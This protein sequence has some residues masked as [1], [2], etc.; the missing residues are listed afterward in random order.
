[1]TIVA[2]LLPPVCPTKKVAELETPP[3][4]L[5]LETLILAAPMLATLLDVTVAC[6]WV[7]DRKVVANT[8]PFH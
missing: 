1:M 3:P 7:L 8:F 4:T 5:A 2:K 6:S